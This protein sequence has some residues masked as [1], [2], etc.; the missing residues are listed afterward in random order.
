MIR[1]VRDH[2]PKYYLSVPWDVDHFTGDYQ[3]H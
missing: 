1:T 3:Q 2:V